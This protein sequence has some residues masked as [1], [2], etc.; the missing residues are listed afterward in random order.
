[1]ELSAARR[2]VD[3][4]RDDRSLEAG[5]SGSTPV[6]KGFFAETLSGSWKRT[7][8]RASSGRPLAALQLPAVARERRSWSTDP[9][10]VAWLLLRRTPWLW[11]TERGDTMTT[12]TSLSVAGRTGGAFLL[13]WPLLGCGAR[14]PTQA[15]GLPGTMAAQSA[16]TT[17][18]TGAFGVQPGVAAEGQSTERA[19]T[20]FRLDP[21]SFIQ[22][23]PFDA[24]SVHT[25][26]AIRLRKQGEE[27][28]C[29]WGVVTGRYAINPGDACYPAQ[30]GEFTLEAICLPVNSEVVA[31][32]SAVMQ[33]EPTPEPTPAPVPC[34]GFGSRSC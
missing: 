33:P 25:C 4:D 23:Q 34:V 7:V 18:G 28:P 12:N 22:G 2:N 17:T 3:G 31:A 14:S 27:L 16:G 5:E 20:S 13:L 29:A 24:V 21:L 8:A 10:D 1:M 30:L 9:S 26:E 15:T 11:A 32:A 19:I 6:P